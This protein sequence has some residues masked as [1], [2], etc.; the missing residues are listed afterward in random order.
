MKQAPAGVRHD[1]SAGT[2][3][4]RN[5][6][7]GSWQCVGLCCSTGG[8]EGKGGGHNGQRATTYVDAPLRAVSCPHP[9]QSNMV[10][11]FAA[12]AAAALPACPTAR[13]AHAM[14]HRAG[15]APPPPPKNKKAD[16]PPHSRPA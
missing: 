16:A 14:G 12:N 6:V 7:T 9:K 3:P 8:Q 15:A 4:I 2:T 10:V 5:R 13:N 11:E 1:G